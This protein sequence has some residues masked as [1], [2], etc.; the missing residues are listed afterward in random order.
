MSNSK[1]CSGTCRKYANY[2]DKPSKEYCNGVKLKGN[3]LVYNSSTGKKWGYHQEFPE[4]IS[5][6]LPYF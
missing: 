6:S 1:Y 5:C 3:R 2:V 4:F